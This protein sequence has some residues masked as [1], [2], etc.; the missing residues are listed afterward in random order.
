MSSA[1]CPGGPELEAALIG[2]IA[3]LEA[4]GYDENAQAAGVTAVEVIE[5]AL[6]GSLNSDEQQRVKRLHSLAMSMLQARR[7]EIDAEIKRVG[8]AR[9]LLRSCVRV[10]SGSGGDVDVAG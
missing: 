4:N 10:P 6:P 2:L 7:G 8:E 9:A 3:K 1:A 5:A